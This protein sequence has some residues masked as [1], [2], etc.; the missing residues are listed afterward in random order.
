MASILAIAVV[1]A[2]AGYFIDRRQESRQVW[3]QSTFAEQ[4]LLQASSSYDVEMVAFRESRADSSLRDED[5]TLHRLSYLRPAQGFTEAPASLS[6]TFINPNPPTAPV[7]SIFTE[8]F[9]LYAS[10]VIVS[11]PETPVESEIEASQEP[12]SI[13]RELIPS[14]IV[15]PGDTLW[16]IG[17]QYETTWPTLAELNSL[18]NPDLIYPGQAISLPNPSTSGQDIVSNNP[19]ELNAT[20]DSL[21]TV[22]SGDTLSAI[23]SQHGI[24][25]SQI[26]RINQIPNPDL[27]Y[28]GDRLVLSST[29]RPPVAYVSR[30]V[31]PVTR[32]V[33]QAAPAYSPAP[34]TRAVAPAVRQVTP[35]T[36]P[37]NPGTTIQSG[38]ATWY[39]PGFEGNITYC[40][41]VYDSRQYTAASNTLPCGS[42]VTVSNQVTGASVTVTIT[43]RGGFGHAMDL[44]HAAFSAI[45]HPSAG[46]APIVVSAAK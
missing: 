35:P 40:G 14:H 25:W 28:P 2:G 31:A 33:K 23:G 18:P 15:A 30:Q 16:A 6:T 1:I 8:D 36:R 4:A 26:A 9:Y 7:S 17:L 44:S 32:S 38:V 21:Y 3:E 43:D 37:V 12:V 45:A 41:Q 19:D 10:A 11:E 22:Q 42:V 20:S 24:H 5:L 39:G 13:E 34:V 29:A 46:V 27:I